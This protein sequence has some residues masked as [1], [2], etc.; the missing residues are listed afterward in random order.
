M[1]QRPSSLLPRILWTE[2]IYYRLHN[3]PPF[4]P[5]LS[6]MNQVYIVPSYFCKIQF[7]I[8]LSSTPRSNKQS[9]S[10]WFFALKLCTDFFSLSCVV[11]KNNSNV[12]VCC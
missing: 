1:K 6:Q 8:I 5:I 9:L 10:S 3:R 7:N 11:L 12:S 2:M 4:A